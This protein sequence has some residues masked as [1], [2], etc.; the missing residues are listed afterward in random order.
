MVLLSCEKK[1]ASTSENYAVVLKSVHDLEKLLKEEQYPLVSSHR[2]GDAEGFPE[3]C[4]ETFKRATTFGPSI[5]ETD[6]AM[7]KDSVLVLM[8]D[9]RID[10][11]S[12]GKGFVKDYNYSELRSFV[13]KDFTGRKTAHKIPTL[14]EA[15]IW[16]KEKVIYTLNVKRGVPY[17]KVVECIR[18]NTAE[19]YTA[20]ITYN[21]GQARAFHTLAPDIWLSV[22]A[23]GEED[24]LRLKKYKVSTDRIM[25]FVGI[26]EPSAQTI[27]YMK[28]RRIPMILGTIGNLDKSA[29]VNGDH[30][31]YA[32]FE[33]GINIL[34]ADRNGAAAQQALDFARD[35]GLTSEFIDT[36]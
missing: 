17:E 35:R 4:I 2:G 29:R 36:K 24:I 13:L 7:T 26:T 8:H 22:S 34:S 3:N 6:V 11:T 1:V 15:L 32:L 14:D 5:V 31:Y 25:A 21:A 9:D 30:L 20:V 27:A 12:T 23:N 10:R 33:K 18:K 16:G 28:N 19:P